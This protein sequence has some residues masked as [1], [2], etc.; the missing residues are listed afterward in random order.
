MEK[1]GPVYEIPYRVLITGTLKNVLTAGRCISASGEA[2][3]ITRCIPQAAL[4][5]QAAGSAAAIAI[6]QS[7]AVQDIDILQLRET[8]KR[9]GMILDINT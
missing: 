7:L 2:W 5:G 9:D 1:P 8:L 6:E 4:T 3:E